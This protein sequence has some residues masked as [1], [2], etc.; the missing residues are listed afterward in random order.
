MRSRKWHNLLP[1]QTL[2]LLRIHLVDEW[3]QWAS[4]CGET[5]AECVVGLF[6]TLRRN[7]HNF[8]QS[9][10]PILKGR[11][12]DSAWL[13]LQE[14]QTVKC[15]KA[16]PNKEKNSRSLKIQK[17]LSWIWVDTIWG[18]SENRLPSV[19]ARFD[20]QVR[21]G[22]VG[23][24]EKRRLLIMMMI[25]MDQDSHPSC[26]FCSQTFAI[27]PILPKEGQEVLPA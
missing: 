23:G 1:P 5:R 17:Q 6:R 24:D 3:C 9:Y 22:G 7:G 27:F 21:I 13:L 8:Q 26:W 15:P 18:P 19:A 4:M 2:M 16:R 25:Q 11:Q 14:L 10:N 12:W 20:F